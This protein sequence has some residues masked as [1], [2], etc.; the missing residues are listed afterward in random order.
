VLSALSQVAFVP[1]ESLLIPATGIAVPAPSLNSSIVPIS[2]AIL[3][4]LVSPYLMQLLT[5]M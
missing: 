4:A 2:I 1:L 3:V 5:D